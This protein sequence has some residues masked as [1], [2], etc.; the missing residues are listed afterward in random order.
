MAIQRKKS[1][2]DL[3]EQA[4]RIGQLGEA[5]KQRR[6]LTT[7]LADRVTRAGNI[8]EKYIDRILNN[9][10]FKKEFDKGYN[11]GYRGLNNPA[12]DKKFS[13]RVYAGSNG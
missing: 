10:T 8:G 4:Q 3:M 5:L 7:T 6:G 12:M 13:K 2:A 1:I 9:K 11:G